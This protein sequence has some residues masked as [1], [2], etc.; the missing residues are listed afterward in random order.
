MAQSK[1][2]SFFSKREASTVDTCE[3]EDQFTEVS[4]EHE[5]GE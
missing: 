4:S 2:R 3:L 1:L 5:H